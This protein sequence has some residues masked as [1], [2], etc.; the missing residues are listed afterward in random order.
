MIQDLVWEQYV[1]PVSLK[2]LLQGNPEAG[3]P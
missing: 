3:D 2:A 1:L